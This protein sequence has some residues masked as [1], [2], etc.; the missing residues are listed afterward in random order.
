MLIAV[1][2]TL[3]RGG[4]LHEAYRLDELDM[5]A[6]E[7]LKGF[8]MYSL[9]AYPYVVQGD[10]EITVEL[11]N[12]DIV[13]AYQIERM[14]RGAGYQVQA[15][16]TSQGEATIFYMTPEEDARLQNPENSWFSKPEPIQ[17]GD[18]MAFKAAKAAVRSN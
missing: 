12:A 3:R 9:G 2:G 11:Y 17:D 6:R 13:T 15:V 16:S 5:L 4:G 14:E 7:T 18:W 8:D 10:G 1:Y